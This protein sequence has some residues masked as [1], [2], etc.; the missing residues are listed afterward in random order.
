MKG[1]IVM[2]IFFGGWILVA[3]VLAWIVNRIKRMLNVDPLEQ[4]FHAPSA[5]SRYDYPQL[6]REET[7]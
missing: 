7:K 3:V 2:F 6:P 5:N 1:V 4:A